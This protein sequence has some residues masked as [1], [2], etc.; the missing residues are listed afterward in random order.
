PFEFFLDFLF[1]ISYSQSVTGKLCIVV[2]FAFYATFSIS[3]EYNDK[4]I[5]TN[6]LI[7]LCIQAFVFDICRIGFKLIDFAIDIAIGIVCGCILFK[8]DLV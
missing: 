3:M 8:I 4:C 5:T 2:G 1:C 7:E 6:R